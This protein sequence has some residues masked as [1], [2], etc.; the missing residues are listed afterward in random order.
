MSLENFESDLIKK[1]VGSKKAF[2]KL[3]KR[4]KP[5]HFSNNALRWMFELITDYHGKYKAMPTIKVVRAEL[6]KTAFSPNKRK[7]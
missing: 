3:S 5:E 7:K 1:F 2:I 4:L 6:A